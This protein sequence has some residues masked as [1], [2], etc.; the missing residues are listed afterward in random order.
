MSYSPQSFLTA[1]ST[2]LGG[3]EVGTGLSIT[4]AGLI[5]NAGVTQLT[6]AATIKVSAATGNITLTDVGVFSITGTSNQVTA[7]ASTGAVTLSLPQ[8]IATNSL[9]TFGSVT[10]N[11]IT[12]TGSLIALGS[13]AGSSGQGSNAV[14]IGN[15][16][17]NSNQG[18]SSVAIGASAGYNNQQSNAVAIGNSAG[19]TTQGSGAVAVGQGAGNTTGGQ[20]ANSV[21]IG[22]FAGTAQASYAIAIGYNAGAF[23]QTAGSIVLSAGSNYLGTATNA[24]FYVSPVRSDAT[25]SATTWSVYYNSATK[26]ITTA[27]AGMFNSGP[28]LINQSSTTTNVGYLTNNQTTAV[29]SVGDPA[30][31]L[32]LTKQWS[33][34]TATSTTNNAT[35]DTFRWLDSSGNVIGTSGI[36]G[37]IYVYSRGASGANAFNAV[38]TIV[39][40]GNGTTDAVLT[41]V[42]SHGRGT[43]PVS[44]IQVANDGAGG[45]IKITTT[46]INNTGVVTGGVTVMSFV[47]LL[48]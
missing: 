40:G 39:S 8:S 15:N 45:G 16:A 5:S 47:G 2:S 48:V 4:G 41:S 1:T 44:S 6:G 18:S 13:F 19:Q 43:S 42:A 10:A 37:H 17:G 46:Y 20:G 26:E 32:T 12:Q 27:T 22:S 7:S 31:T 11:T 9:V 23:T 33:I 24:G 36:S 29:L 28:V 3:V 30:G 38:Y 25:T 14:A 35:V 21:A 34:S